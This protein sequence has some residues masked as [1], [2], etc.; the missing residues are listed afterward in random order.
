MG[1]QFE[2][3]SKIPRGRG[4]AQKTIALI[5]AM[6]QIA[7][8]AHPITGRGVGYKLFLA[9]L[10]ASM[11]RSDMQRVYRLLKEAREEE[12][13]PWEWIV[14]ES[15]GLEKKPSWDDPEHYTRCVIR[16]Y[17]R[18]YWDQQECRVEVWSEKGTVRGVLQPVLDEYGVGFRVMHG[19]SSAT[20][21]YNIAQD[22]DDGRNLIALY[23]GDWDPSGLY[24]SDRDL[25]DRLAKYDGHHVTLIRIALTR[26][27]LTGLP[28][29]PAS[30]KRRDP[31][32]KWF[33]SNY[34]AKCWELDALDPNRLRSVVEENI[35]RFIEQEAWHRCK[36][37]ERAER[38]SLHEFMTNWSNACD[39]PAAGD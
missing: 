15:H 23:V 37:V 19:F 36:T 14:D 16:G 20:E 2:T 38:N 28:S 34:G 21:V 33:V 32:F 6:E 18:D 3:G 12:I 22:S 11:S 1:E 30:D 9:G 39:E 13:I 27:Q 29:F 5:E 7:A 10:I 8:A 25:P 17:R 31:R 4:R 26:K 24:M 35:L